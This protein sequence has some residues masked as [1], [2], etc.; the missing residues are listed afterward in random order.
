M[1]DGLRVFEMG[2]EIGGDG[3]GYCVRGCVCAGVRVRVCVCVC[4]CVGVMGTG[5]G[6]GE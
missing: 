1:H 5:T 4:V 2:R 6:E 3:D